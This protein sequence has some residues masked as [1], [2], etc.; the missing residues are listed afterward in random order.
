MDRV[1][2]FKSFAIGTG[3]KTNKN[4]FLGQAWIEK[5]LAF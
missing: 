5:N 3:L 2:V 1:R 4:S